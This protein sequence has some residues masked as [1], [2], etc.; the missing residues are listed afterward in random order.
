VYIGNWRGKEM[1]PYGVY[2]FTKQNMQYR[3][4]FKKSKPHGTGTLLRKPPTGQSNEEKIYEGEWMNGDKHGQ[5]KYY[6]FKDVFYEGNWVR[7]KK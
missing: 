2:N 7:N 6:Y 5:G 3:G 4:S 1:E